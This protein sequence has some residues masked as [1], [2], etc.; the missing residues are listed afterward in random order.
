M[1]IGAQH[2]EDRQKVLRKSKIGYHTNYQC[3]WTGPNSTMIP[4]PQIVCSPKHLA[5]TAIGKSMP[6]HVNDILW[7]VSSCDS[8]VLSKTTNLV[9]VS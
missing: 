5:F 9:T 7:F 4:I 2:G 8:Y 6:V 1:K 3:L